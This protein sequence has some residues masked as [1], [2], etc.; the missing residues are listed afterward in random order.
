M[1]PVRLQQN[2]RR[3]GAVIACLCL[4]AIGGWVFRQWFIDEGW[5][6][7]SAD[8]VEQVNSLGATLEPGGIGTINV[9]SSDADELVL[10][11]A[12]YHRDALARHFPDKPPKF[13]DEVVIRSPHE[14]D[15][16]I[17]LRGGKV[18]SINPAKFTVG[19]NLTVQSWKLNGSREIKV[20]KETQSPNSFLSLYFLEDDQQE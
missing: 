14:Q 5:Q 16:L 8:F 7:L 13:I 12:Y 19:M 17:W 4:V 1:C 2:R 6:T 11:P 9:S 3:L 15:A 20:V 10:L 18:I